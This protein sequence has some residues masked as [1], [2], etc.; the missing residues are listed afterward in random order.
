M[1]GTSIKHSVLALAVTVCTFTGAYAN[2]EILNSD[3]INVSGYVSEP[4]ATDMELENVKNE[5]RKQKQAIQVNKKKAKTYEK[6]GKSTEKLAD[7]TEEM[8]DERKESKATIEKYNKKIE[9]LMEENPGKDCDEYVKRDKVS[10]AQAAP[11]NHTV[12]IAPT[13]GNGPKMSDTIKAMPYVGFTSFQSE[14]E[15]LEARIS[16]GIRVESDITSR[17]S[18]GIG[19]N[20]TDMTTVDNNCIGLYCQ[21]TGYVNNFGQN[22]EIEYQNLNFDITGKFFITKNNRFRPY[23]GLGLGYNRTTMNYANN[24]NFVDPFLGHNFGNEEIISSSINGQILAGSEI[25]I[26]KSIGM[27]LEFGYKKGLGSS[28]N[29]DNNRPLTFDQDRLRRLNEELAEANIFSINA[30]MVVYF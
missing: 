24:N 12:A 16:A 1:K 30:G 7:V 29:T 11:M 13:S 27:N 26:T 3:P 19:F 18:V 5:L 21:S 20:Y 28:F 6:L 9:C 25:T 17:L 14:N 23:V 4:E 10:V 15:N 8:I 2:E 22:R